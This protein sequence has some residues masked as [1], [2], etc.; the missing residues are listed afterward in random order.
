MNKSRS[1]AACF[2][3]DGINRRNDSP[4]RPR[5]ACDTVQRMERINVQHQREISRM[6][7]RD[8]LGFYEVAYAP[9]F[10]MQKHAHESPRCV[11]VLKGSV[12]HRSSCDLECGAQSAVFVARD[13]AHEDAI[14]NSG[15]QCFIVE[16]GAAWRSR[17]TACPSDIDHLSFAEHRGEMAGVLNRIRYECGHADDASS[18]IVDGLLLEVLGRAKRFTSHQLV[19]APAWIRSVITVLHDRFREHVTIAELAAEANVHPV[20]LCREFRRRTGA[21]IGAYL[22]QLRIDCA[23]SGLVRTNQPIAD[24]ALEAG[25]SSQAHLS[26]TFRRSMNLSPKAYR[27]LAKFR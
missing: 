1:K 27:D 22:R 17:V 26:T 18:L 25:F 14:G 7:S 21:T 5:T 12:R 13:E 16:L 6:W 19:T 20:H 24:I 10:E 15:A 2:K 3:A 4:L 9:L 23:C 11:L 8:G